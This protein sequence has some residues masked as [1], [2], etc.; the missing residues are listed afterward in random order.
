MKQ[1]DIFLEFPC[2]VSDPVNTDNLISVIGINSS[3]IYLFKGFLRDS[4]FCSPQHLQHA[5]STLKSEVSAQAPAIQSVFQ[6]SGRRKVW[7]LAWKVKVKMLV[8][9]SCPTLCDP[10]DCR[11]PGSS[12]HVILQARILEWFAISFSR[13]S[14]HPR[15]WTWVC[16]IASRFF[17]TE[18]PGKP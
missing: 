17:I 10:M 4:F 8:T 15:H 6:L 16:H 14:S 7:R 3:F 13:V 18:P 5:S 2:F 1:V 12:V 9:Q 11:P